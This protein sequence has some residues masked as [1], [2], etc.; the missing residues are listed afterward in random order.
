MKI[1]YKSKVW[2]DKGN[3]TAVQAFEN[4]NQSVNALYAILNAKTGFVISDLEYE[5]LNT[6]EKQFFV[7][8]GNENTVDIYKTKNSLTTD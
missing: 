1:L 4:L 5:K 3:I 8:A 6:G 2:L 7:D